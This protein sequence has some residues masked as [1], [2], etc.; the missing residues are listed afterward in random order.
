MITTVPTTNTAIHS[1]QRILESLQQDHAA[2]DA[3]MRSDQ[4]DVYAKQNV[5]RSKLITQLWRKIGRQVLAIHPEVVEEVK[6][7]SSDKV[8]GEIL[9][10]LPYINPLV[11]YADPPV[12]PSWRN[13]K[14]KT[15]LLGFLT[16]GLTNLQVNQIDEVPRYEQRIYATTD[17]DANRFA[18]LVVMEVLDEIDRVIDTE[19][20][21]L[22]FY[23]D[24]ALTLAEMAEQVLSR[25]HFYDGAGSV[26]PALGKKWMR[27]MLSTIIGSL[28][29]LCSTTL[30]AEP[31]PA[32]TVAKKIPKR[33][34]RQPLSLF[35]VGWT[36]GA[37]LTRFRQSRAGVA[38]SE[39]DDLGHQQDPQHRRAHFK[40]QPYG[41]G[42]AL[43]KL[44]FV[45]AYWTHLERLGVEGVNTSR[46][47]PRVNGKGAAR[48]SVDTVLKMGVVPK[49]I[50]K[51]GA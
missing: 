2:A 19:F 32:K 26:S 28:F 39:Q 20:N 34:V 14:E 41:P 47:V 6:L 45:S 27:D 42:M 25:F 17:P 48:D 7:A 21:T 23:Y 8:P 18:V 29:Y 10:V 50:E 16:C 11:V 12:F 1:A 36:T 38:P 4:L 40:M 22:T 43:R 13:K 37:A 5:Q 31:V 9:R 35:K 51:E 30:E 44:I 33:I 15:R 49:L 46:V 3:Y 24:Q